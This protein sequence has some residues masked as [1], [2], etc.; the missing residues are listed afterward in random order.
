[1]QFECLNKQELIAETEMENQGFEMWYHERLT[2]RDFAYSFPNDAV[3]PFY[4]RSGKIKLNERYIEYTFMEHE[5]RELLYLNTSKSMDDIAIRNNIYPS[6]IEL[7]IIEYYL[8]N[9]L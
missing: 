4:N 7:A 2:N 9:D 8:K 3:V 5:A 6:Y 1:M